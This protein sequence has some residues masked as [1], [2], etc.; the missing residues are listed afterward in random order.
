[1]VSIDNYSRVGIECA[2][3]AQG[4]FQEQERSFRI[5]AA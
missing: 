1:M 5:A 4:F 2:P 3:E